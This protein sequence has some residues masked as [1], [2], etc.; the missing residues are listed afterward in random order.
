MADLSNL[1]GVDTVQELMFFTNNAVSGIL[2]SGGMAVFFFIIL[3][4]LLKNNEPFE[5][6]LAVASWVMFVVSAFFWLAHLLPTIVP[7]AFLVIAAFDLLYLYAS[8]Q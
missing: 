8:R 3:V 1:T 7:L 5:N 4:A 6:A 2:F